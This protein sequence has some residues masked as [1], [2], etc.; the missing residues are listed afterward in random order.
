[1][2]TDPI[3][4]GLKGVLF[5]LDGTVLDS[6]PW[7]IKA[8][9]EVFARHGIK[10]EDEFLYLNE[11][12]IESSHL[13]DAVGKQGF[14]RDE[15]A[16]M[17][18]LLEQAE[19]FKGK[20]ARFVAPFPDAGPVLKRLK[21]R[22]LSLALIT[23]STRP[24]VERILGRE[25]SDLFSVIVTGDQV[26]NGKPHPEPYLTGLSKLGLSPDEAVAVENA[27]AGINS[28]KAAG[29]TCLALTTTLAQ[30]HLGRADMV[31]PSLSLVAERI[32]FALG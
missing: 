12:A 27:P 26:E 22:E 31:L 4:P 20:Y 17:A 6:M 3:P 21:E 13:L 10:I 25:I 5:D 29:L 11:G 19:H 8:W 7:H 23:S 15:P 14:P 16:I 24:V 28:A 9:Q 18:L 1:M 32:I 2:K 30:K